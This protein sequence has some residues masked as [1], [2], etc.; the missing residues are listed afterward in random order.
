MTHAEVCAEMRRWLEEQRAYS[1][2]GCAPYMRTLAYLDSLL[3]RVESL[4]AAIEGE[5]IAAA[6]EADQR[7]VWASERF[8]RAWSAKMPWNKPRLHCD[9]GPTER[10]DFELQGHHFRVTPI[11]KRGVDTGRRRYLVECLT[12]EEEIH[13]A[14]TGPAGMCRQHLEDRG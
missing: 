5:V 9:A 7:G 10:V 3:A 13:E 2:T 8:V 4:P 6:L 11:D 14:T 1:F 12:C